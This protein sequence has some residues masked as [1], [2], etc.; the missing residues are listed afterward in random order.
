MKAKF[1]VNGMSCAACQAHVDKAVSSIDGVSFCNVNLLT[2]SM[3]VEWDESKTNEKAI[4]RAVKH[5]GYSVSLKNQSKLQRTDYKLAKLIISFVVLAILMYV[6]MGHM[7]GAPLPAFID[8]HIDLNNVRWFC[9]IQLILAFIVIGIYFVDYYVDGFK[10]L[11]KLKPNMSSLIAVGSS[12]S[13]IYGIIMTIQSFIAVNHSDLMHLEMISMNLYFESSAMILVFVGLGKYFESLSKKRTTKAIEELIALSPDEAVVIRDGKEAL[14]GIDEVSVGDTVVVRK[15]DRVPVD[16]VISKGSA[17]FDE[18]SITGESMPCFKNVGEHVYSSTIVSSGYVEITVEKVGEDTSISNIVK[19]VEEASNSKA[20]ISKLA[21]KISLIFVP[22]IFAIAL[23]TL[24]VWWV[25]SKEFATAFNFAITVLVIACPCA[26]GL[27]T[28]VAI[29]VASGKGSKAGILI[30]NAEIL[31]KTHSVKTVVLDKT[32]TITEGKPSVTDVIKL[33]ETNYLAEVKAIEEKSE[34]P[35]SNAIVEYCSSIN[36]VLEVESYTSIEGV[37]VSGIVGGSTFKIGNKK[38]FATEMPHKDK[39]D[40]LS[41]E[42]KTVL[43]VLRNE[44]PVLMIAIKDKVKESSKIAVET[45]QN[46]GI[47]V[48][49]LTGDN[50]VTAKA[51]ASEIGIIHVYSEVLPD[52]KNDYIRKIQE[53]SQAPVAMVGDGVND[54]IAL[55]SADVGISLGGG[56]DIAMNTSDIVLQ[57][58]DLLDIANAISLSRATIRTIKIGLFWAFFYNSVCVLIAMGL[59]NWAGLTINPM[60]GSIAMSISSVSV[61]LNALTLNLWKPKTIINNDK[62]EVKMETIVLNVNGMMCQMCVKHV[63][64][65][66]EGVAGVETVVVSLENKNATVTGK[67]I[68]RDALVT[69]VVE[70]GY[71]CK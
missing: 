45:L 20:P 37:G 63:T 38:L 67:N 12:A 65:A 35:L 57:R 29:M 21:D 41:S 54:S 47:N 70:A 58:N 60:I 52:Q 13:L 69:A 44:T 55:A 3:E 34:H 51:I 15:G 39:F 17:S 49:M 24:V 28:P 62:G 8:P 68:S 22:V 1:D 61:V 48:V 53:E 27:A 11:V 18:A 43:F 4:E 64:K 30:K 23:G 6:S 16:G 9:I 40:K 56:S 2:N 42:G 25:I 5:A 33:V 31:E 32:G 14:V 71:E 50:E 46:A 10:R 19:L 26:L 59:F 66:L 36:E 7:F